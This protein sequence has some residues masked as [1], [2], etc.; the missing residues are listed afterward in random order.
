[1]NSDH[2]PPISSVPNGCNVLTGPKYSLLRP[3]FYSYQRKN[4]NT[5]D[6]KNGH[7]LISLGGYDE[8]NIV[9]EILDSI[10]GIQF[11]RKFRITVVLGVKE[12]W[13]DTIKKQVYNY[14]CPVD[15]KINV[16]NMAAL[17]ADCDL[18]IGAAGSTSWERCCLGLPTLMF[19]V[20]DN[21]MDIAKELEKEHTAIIVKSV[22]K[23]V[24][25]LSEIFDD[26]KKLVSMSYSVRRIADGLGVGRVVNEMQI[27]Q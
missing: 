26:P 19:V 2:N 16:I 6:G 27:I 3:E 9:G 17:M 18:C 8:N 1:M 23:L 20:A 14:P 4:I 21:Q 12:I 24:D 10:K 13:G 5:V 7:M 15:I 22:D 25:L 11:P